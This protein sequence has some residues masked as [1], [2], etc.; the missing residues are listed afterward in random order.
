M[1]GYEANQEH[2]NKLSLLG[3]PLARRSGRRC[4]LCQASGVKLQPLEVPPIPK[5]PEFDR[6]LFLCET[7]ITQIN[8]P[9][10]IE[11]AR[12]RCLTNAIWSETQVVQVMAVRILRRL[13]KT[14]AWAAE[15]L[16]D[17]YLEPETEQWIDQAN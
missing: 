10:K 1:A 15:L 7:C 13:A 17:L 11:P 4:E 3:K 6:T 14:E 9:D 5:E 16:Q 8:K 12:W 2:L